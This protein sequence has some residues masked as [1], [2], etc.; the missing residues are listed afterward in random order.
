[1]LLFS[2][3]IPYDITNL[4]SQNGL[5]SFGA[6]SIMADTQGAIAAATRSN[7]SIYGIDP[8]GLTTMGDDDITVSSLG[9]PRSGLGQAGLNRE[10]MREQMSLR[11][12]SDET[13]GF[14]VVNT[15]QFADA[16]ARIVDDNSAYYV[17]AYYPPSNKRDGKFHKI[18]VKTTR[19]GLT[20]RSR[21]GYQA[22]RGKVPAATP[23]EAGRPSP[24][25]QEALN[26]PIPVSRLPMRVFAAPFK[27]TAPN[28]TVLFGVE[29]AG[30][31]LALAQD[32][33]I[34]LSYQAVDAQGKTRAA[35]TDNFT[36][37]LQPETRV[38]VQ[39]TGFR[40]LNRIA[41]PPGRYAMR[42][43]ARDVAAGT[44]G[45]VTYDLEVPDFSKQALS[46]SGVIMT[47][48]SGSAM[49]TAKTDDQTKAVL[50]ASP[51][52]ARTFPQND[53]IALFAEIYDNQTGSAHRVNITTTIQ[54]DDGRVLFKAEDERNSSELQGSKGGYGYALRIPLNEIAPG[55]Y[56][57]HLQAK[58]SLGNAE[59]VGRQIRIVVTP[60]VNVQR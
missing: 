45:S 5:A 7:I 59:G 51:N 25:L 32:G 27:G 9:D 58:S 35:S 3:G 12:L 53:E 4:M 60:P 6:N 14:A 44:T 57:L 41:L 56:V 49:I 17:L 36:T 15:N 22:P 39:Q 21:Q 40:M 34:E 23:T 16:Y 55:A 43:A 13:G 46:V 42:L 47:S 10:L 31:N 2:E 54:T 24:E 50:P 8:R 20:V 33:K 11:T 26:S 38:R 29:L 52:A 37:N 28:A 48:M 19:P 1:M 18:K 30:R